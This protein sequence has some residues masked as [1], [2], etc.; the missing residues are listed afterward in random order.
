[1]SLLFSW[2]EA[3]PRSCPHGGCGSRRPAH[4]AGLR[5]FCLRQHVLPRVCVSAYVCT[6]LAHVQTRMES[7]C[8]C[9]TCG[10]TGC[11]PPAAVRSFLHGAPPAVPGRSSCRDLSCCLASAGTGCCGVSRSASPRRGGVQSSRGRP[12]LQPAG[13]ELIARLSGRDS[14]ARSA[15]RGCWVEIR[16]LRLTH[17][18]VWKVTGAGCPPL[19]LEMGEGITSTRGEVPAPQAP[20]ASLP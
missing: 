20:S 10:W 3:R 18:R 12:W 15:G 16:A 4:G 9:V 11:R 2:T 7:L 8:F 17:G 6:W 19:A 13:G 5:G 14:G 1:M